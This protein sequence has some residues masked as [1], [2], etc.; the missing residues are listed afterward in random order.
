MTSRA[1]TPNLSQPSFPVKYQPNAQLP[2]VADMMIHHKKYGS[3]YIKGTLGNFKKISG[4]YGVSSSRQ[5]L[6]KSLVIKRWERIDEILRD[7]LGLTPKQ[8]Q[9]TMKLLWYEVFCGQAFPSA[10]VLAG[11]Y[12]ETPRLAAWRAEQGLGRPARRG[13]IGRATVWRTIRLL[14]EMGL[15]TVVNRIITPYR[16]QTSNLYLLRKLMILIARELARHLASLCPPYFILDF[17]MTWGQLE[18]WLSRWEQKKL[19]LPDTQ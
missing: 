1:T 10:S 9:V 2:L 13:E 8:C 17:K 15:I 16:R 12:E 19:P 4:S 6:T 3:I 5:I 11:E 14:R 7:D 18:V